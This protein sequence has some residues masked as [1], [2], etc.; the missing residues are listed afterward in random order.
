MA[1]EDQI[2]AAESNV[3]KIGN[4]A[5]YQKLDLPWSVIERIYQM[6]MEG[7]SVD[8]VATSLNIELEFVLAWMPGGYF[9]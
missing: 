9:E 7:Y 1:N 2:R 4:N 3:L 8:D 5:N 6:S